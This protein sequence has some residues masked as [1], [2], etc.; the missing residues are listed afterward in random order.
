MEEDGK[1]AIEMGM[2][3]MRQCPV[4]IYNNILLYD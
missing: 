2:A 1:K 4:S 3:N